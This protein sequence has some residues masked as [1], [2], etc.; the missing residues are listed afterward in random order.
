MEGLPWHL[1]APSLTEILF[2]FHLSI[3]Q[4]FRFFPLNKSFHPSAFSD[5][6]RILSAA[7]STVAK[8]KRAVR[9]EGINFFIRKPIF[10]GEGKSNRPV[11]LSKFFLGQVRS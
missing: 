3:F 11:K 5:L 8:E 2:G 10:E 7:D 6:D 1:I 4:L 9:I